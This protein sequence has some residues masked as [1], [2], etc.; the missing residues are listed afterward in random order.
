MRRRTLV[1]LV[2]LV[3]LLG[4]VAFA[5]VS[6]SIGVNT[7]AGREQIR[8]LIQQ[9]VGS[10]INGRVYVGKVSGGLL[11]SV[12]IDSFAI[13][14]ADDS[15]FVST[16]K[17]TLEYNP[18]DLIDRRV[19]IRTATIEHPMIRLEKFPGGDWNHWRIFRR[20][21]SNRPRVPGRS[22]GDFVVLDSVTVRNGSFLMTRPWAPNDSLRGAARD[23]VMRLALG[24]TAREI[25]RSS[26]GLT[27]TLRWRNLNAF[28]PHVR[29]NHPDSQSLG[30][31]F[32]FERGSVDEQEPP[33]QF[34]NARGTVR[35]LGDSVFLDVAHFDLPASTGSATGKVWWG[36][37]LPERWD[38]RIRADSVALKDVAWVY[39][40]LPRVGSG[41]TNLRIH[42]SIDNLS[43]MEYALTEL[44][45]RSGKSRLTGGMTFVIG[46]PVLAIKDVD[47][48]FAPINFDVVR[49]LAG[50]PFPVDWQGDLVGMVQGPGGP[51][52]N[53][54]LDTANITFRDSHV[55]GAVSRFAGR[56]ELNILLPEFTEFHGFQVA[57][58]LLD[59]R[60]VQFLFPG[61]PRIGGTISGSATLDSS[62]MDVRFSNADITHTNGPEAPS[63]L[64]GKGRVTYGEKYMR[65]DVDL[66][67]KRI[68]MPM[69]SRAYQLGLTGFFSGPIKASGISPNLRVIADLT[70]AG[71]RFTYDGTV[72][73]DPLS[74]G[75]HGAGRVETLQLGQLIASY[76]APAAW[77]TGDY[78][79][80]FVGDTNDLGSL[81]GSASMSL[82]RSEFGDVRVF[83]SRVVARF[84]DRRLFIDTLRVESTAVTIDAA[85]AIGLT[86]DRSDSLRY[87][88]Q[89]DSLGGLRQYVSML[90]RPA[91]GAP[92]DSL[93]G[94]AAVDG[95]MQGSLQ[96]FRLFGDVAGTKVVLRRE[97]GNEIRGTFDLT[98]AFSGPTGS[99]SLRS[100]TLRFG[101]VALD[102]LG[103]ALRVNEG[104]TGA[105]TVGIR[106]TNGS[107]LATQGEFAKSDSTTFVSIRSLSVATDSS[108][109]LMSGG[110][111]LRIR[112]RDVTIDSL[113]LLNEHRGRISL[114]A[115][116]PDSGRAR[117]LLR[118]DSVPLRDVGILAQIRAPMAGWASLTVA[119]AGSS[120][121]PVI[122][123]EAR[124]SNIRF[125]SLRLD[126]GV[127]RVEYASNRAVV[128]MDLTRAGTSVL[129]MQ[130]SLPLALR[131]FGA[132]LLDDSLQASIRTEGATL[133]LLQALVPG[134]RNAT[135]KL[136]ATID[137][138]GTWK[139]PDVTGSVTVANGEATID[140][141]G[142]RLKGIQVD[143][144]LFGHADSLA[145]RR[146][147]GW[148]GAS[149]ADSVSLT[150]YVAYSQF[151]NPVL[152]LRLDARSFFAMDRRALARLSISTERGGLTLRGPLSGAVLSGGVLVDRG[153][154]YLPDPELLKK[155]SVDIR[156][157][158][159][160]TTT[161]NQSVLDSRSR[162]LETVAL[163]GLR[164]TLGEEVALASADADI[165]LTGALTVRSV[166][167]RI[168]SLTIGG[169]DTVQYQVVLDGTL[170]ADRGTYTL[171]LLEVARREF[172]V[173]SGG[174]I[175]FYPSADLPAELNITALHVVKRANQTDLRIRVRLTGPPNNPVVSL[176]SGESWPI[177]QTD[178]VSY[179]A[180]GVP[181]FALGDRETNT[182]Q[183][184]LQNVIPS[185]LTGISGLLGGRLGGV[186][187]QVTPG[188]VDYSFAE[189]AGKTFQSLLYTTRVG[190]E[191]QL[192]ANV[193]ASLST[194]LCQLSGSNS[195]NGSS[196]LQ[197]LTEGLSGKLEYRFSQS[198]ALKAGREPP[199]SANNCGKAVTGRAFIPTPSQWGLSL[200]KS[201][202]F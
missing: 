55:R 16:G 185:A 5:A 57:T 131:Y 94:S 152:N 134:I 29:L 100:R 53:F 30:R 151:T 138:G 196:D 17:V 143:L 167:T 173:Q 10:G 109:W 26:G 95:W 116:I 193:F 35:H 96:G 197:N 64:T 122:N 7:R 120:Q 65:Y 13:R 28:L 199:A 176:E 155:Q 68:S 59:L 107:N 51:L 27:H 201:W 42:N 18:R 105:F 52:T 178:M 67:A 23:S 32:I 200:F 14:G 47:L 175:V 128:R 3:T 115:T 46:N 183:L 60:S 56:G 70:G 182:V 198:M 1:I 158:F 61:F 104:R 20:P 31:E 4:I 15:L 84:D 108:H 159:A 92:P 127:G 164:V 97:V 156:A 93:S 141:L 83:P 119:G 180:F 154:V 137:V 112:G 188:A 123:A 118:A 24:D 40:T 192:S 87:S 101:G 98:N 117:F 191:L 6:V 140:Q 194:G 181:N 69:I 19:L 168:P 149:P 133:D 177:S 124:F 169:V 11:S 125:D 126:S 106:E 54:V 25:R 41:R 33:F 89:A 162:L 111:G 146:F 74:V 21:K 85:G 9:Q 148:N 22:L 110:S 63:H 174:S 195:N 50:G 76:T 161:R 132:K 189:G 90:M 58:D 66:D 37:Q 153:T 12:T 144:G 121:A 77:I 136:L 147:V 172:V 186:N 62:W 102:T 78:R 88:L 91:E 157:Q 142:I 150:G 71:G 72:D 171:K 160:D 44:D 103:F 184:I 202:R 34:S 129:Q 86:A 79:L 81:R 2:S 49:T 113:V 114:S 43:L 36:S 190:G 38:I 45:V 8:L 165:R 139:H 187:F 73:A 75:F 170:K 145:V 39:P 130:A 135:G 166:A 163:E 48:R 82:E 99:V 80:D 179:L